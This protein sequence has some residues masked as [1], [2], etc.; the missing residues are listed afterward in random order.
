LCP[1]ALISEHPRSAEPG[2]VSFEIRKIT[3]LLWVAAAIVLALGIA[4]ELAVYFLGT[5]TFVGD[6][7][8]FA[9]DRERNL[10]TWY[11]TLTMAAASGLLAILAAL[12]HSHD[13]RNRL[14]WS[15]LAII[16]ILLSLDEAASFHEALDAVLRDSFQLSGFLTFPWV[17]IAAPLVL[18]LGVFLIPFLLRLPRRT[19]V[20]F[21]IAGAIFLSGALGLEFIG[22][23]YASIGGWEYLP[24]KILSAAEECLE[25]TGM[26]LFVTSLLQ[27]LA[28]SA[29]EMQIALHHRRQHREGA[30]S[31]RSGTT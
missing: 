11:G 27:H 8:H 22:G 5:E 15:L 26:T 10:P 9:L 19:A 17:I 24:F 6:L 13:P 20:R 1:A 30:S 4:R 31:A 3:G 21:F 16:F 7:R 2:V 12:S 18:A 29:P 14:A 25:I 23:Y 28:K